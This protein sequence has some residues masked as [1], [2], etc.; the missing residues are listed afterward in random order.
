MQKG[1]FFLPEERGYLYDAIHN[2]LFLWQTTDLFSNLSV[3][4]YSCKMLTLEDYKV[5]NP[6]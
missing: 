5:T 1:V 6:L 4:I 2:D 3:I